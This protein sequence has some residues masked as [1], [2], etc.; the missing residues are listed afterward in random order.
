M[1]EFREYSDSEIEDDDVMESKEEPLNAE[2]DNDDDDGD[3]EMNTDDLETIELKRAVE[4]ES[5]DDEDDEDEAAP[6]A[7]EKTVWDEL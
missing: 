5:G 3:I 1:D 7:Q 2:S 6:A 4:E